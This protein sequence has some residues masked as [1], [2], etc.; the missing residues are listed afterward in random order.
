MKSLSRRNVDDE[1][2]RKLAKDG[3]G[4]QVDGPRAW[5]WPLSVA[6]AEERGQAGMVATR[7]A[8]RAGG[9]RGGLRKGTSVG[10]PR[11]ASIA[12]SRRKGPLSVLR[13]TIQKRAFERTILRSLGDNDPE[14]AG[15]CLQQAIEKFLKAFLLSKG[16]QLWQIHS[17]EARAPSGYP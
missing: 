7:S 4:L 2:G 3:P 6:G 10:S 14:M 11:C 5:G 17:L 15:F 9:D 13:G 16:W 8:A 1:G 12:G